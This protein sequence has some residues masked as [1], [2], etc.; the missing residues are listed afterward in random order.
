[1]SNSCNPMD[2]SL[3][4]SSACGI[5][6]ARILEW[7]A[8]SFSRGSSQLRNRTRVS[9]IAGR[10]FTNW[11]IREDL[12]IYRHNKLSSYSPWACTV[13]HVNLLSIKL[14]NFFSEKLFCCI[15]LLYFIHISIDGHLG[16]LITF[17]CNIFKITNK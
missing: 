8:I 2:C 6:Q 16:C 3:P 9:C 13:L 1:M 17:G 5:L 10:F 11:A 7:I 12:A 14:G 4:G 15:E